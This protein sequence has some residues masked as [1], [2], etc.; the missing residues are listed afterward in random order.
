MR[1]VSSTSASNWVLVSEEQLSLDALS[2][3]ATRK[4]CGAIVTFSGVVRDNSLAHDNVEALEYETSVEL[5][6]I[7][8]DEII[9]EARH[10]WPTLVAVGIHHRIGRVDLTETSVIVA[11]SSPHRAEAFDAA[12]YCIDTLKVGV[13]MWKRE[14][15][16]GG[17][18]WSEESSSIVNIEN[19]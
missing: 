11:V 7:R 14:I 3:W 13:P 15:F 19:R 5:A 17:S 1:R 9:A 18:A 12:R 16:E 2:S 4:S 10:R 6:T 8:L